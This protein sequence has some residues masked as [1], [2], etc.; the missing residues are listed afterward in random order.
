[1]FG[2]RQNL[3]AGEAG[4]LGAQ[5]WEIVE[6]PKYMKVNTTEI[7]AQQKEA[8]D[9]L[10]KSMPGDML[11]RLELA[12][13]EAKLKHSGLSSH[14]RISNLLPPSLVSWFAS[15]WWMREGFFFFLAPWRPNDWSRAQVM[16]IPPNLLQRKWKV[17]SE[18]EVLQ[19]QG[20]KDDKA[21][22][23]RTQ[24]ENQEII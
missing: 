15:V 3:A 11:D 14:E 5:H 13:A 7:K 23:I 22:V 24:E 9:D 19:A 1:M 12:A 6:L 10:T 4:P 2:I 20:E 18:Q 21:Q 8:L 17:P 16:E